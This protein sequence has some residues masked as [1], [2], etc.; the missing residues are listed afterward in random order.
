MYSTFTPKGR[1]CAM[2]GFFDIAWFHG[3]VASCHRSSTQPLMSAKWHGE[4]LWFGTTYPRPRQPGLARQRRTGFMSSAMQAYR[5]L[6]RASLPDLASERQQ[7]PPSRQTA[8]C[9]SIAPCR[10]QAEGSSEKEYRRPEPRRGQYSAPRPPLQRQRPGPQRPTDSRQPQQPSRQQQMPQET[11]TSQQRGPPVSQ[12]ER[13]VQ[14]NP[15]GPST[16]VAWSAPTRT[17]TLVHFCL[18][19]HT[20]YGQQIR[21]VGSHENLGGNLLCILHSLH[22]PGNFSLVFISISKNAVHAT[23][24]HAC[25][26][27]LATLAHPV[28]CHALF[29]RLT[30]KAN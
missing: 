3:R 23:R 22:F 8:S 27:F 25:T 2:S 12:Q 21:L 26:A 30:D 28:T 16:S 19:Y 29:M 13:D 11:S 4:G 10:S 18:Q 24:C 1:S 20:N 17:P 5:A 14:R 9:R 15:T 6:D 7:Y